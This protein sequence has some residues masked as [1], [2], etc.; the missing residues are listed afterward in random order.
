MRCSCRFAWRWLQGY[1]GIPLL[2]RLK[3]G[4]QVRDD[5]PK[6][7]L[8]KAGTPTMGGLVMWLGLIVATLSFLAR[9]SAVHMAVAKR[10]GGLRAHRPHGRPDHRTQ[11]ALFGPQAYQKIIGQIGIALIVAFFAYKNVGTKLIVPFGGGLEWDL[12][13]WYVPFTVFV[14]VSMVNGVNLTDGL[15][16]LASGVD[17]DQRADV[18]DHP[19]HNVPS[20]E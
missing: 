4:Q 7:H 16:G 8:S 13:D 10:D 14:I 1:V 6:T 20:A 19:L 11:E 18:Y 12:G 9:R 2:K 15:D 3:L 17:A 5:G